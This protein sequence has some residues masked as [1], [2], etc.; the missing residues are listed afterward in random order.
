MEVPGCG[1]LIRANKILPSTQLLLT[2]FL[3]TSDTTVGITLHTMLTLSF[4]LLSYWVLKAKFKKL[5]T[6][7]TKYVGL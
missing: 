6:F 5:F 7:S 1:G 2:W 3:G 4:G